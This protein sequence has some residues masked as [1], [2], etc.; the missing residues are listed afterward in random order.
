[1]K[2]SELLK[3]FENLCRINFNETMEKGGEGRKRDMGD[4]RSF[5]KWAVLEQKYLPIEWLPITSKKCRKFIGAVPKFLSF[6]L[7]KDINLYLKIY[8]TINL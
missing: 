5:F 1:M 7:T 6:N 4:L 8:F 3:D 2:F